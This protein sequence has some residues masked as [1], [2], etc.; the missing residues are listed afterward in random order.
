[1]KGDFLFLGF[2][3]PD[4][5]MERVFKVDKSPAVQ[6]HK[7][8]WN[9][10]K[11]LESCNDFSYTYISTRPVSEYCQYPKQI[12]F[13]NRWKTQVLN[14]KIEILEIPF[15]NRSVF[16]IITR[17]FSG[18][19]YS[20]KEYNKKANKKGVIVYSVHVPFMLIGYVISKIY[21]IDFIAI[22]TDPPSV[23]LTGEKLL[24]SKLRSLELFISKKLMI[25]ATKVIAVTKELAKDF[26]PESP[27]LV[28]EGI[29]DQNYTN[30][31]IYLKEKNTKDIIKVVYTGSLSKRY[32]ISNIVEAFELLRDENV[33]LEIYGWGDYEEEL[34]LICIKNNNIR[35]KGFVSNNDVINI[36]RSADFL[37]NA[38]SAEDEYVRYSFPSKTLEYML[39]GTPL[40]T[41]ILPSMPDEYKDY[42]LVI[43]DNNPKTICD[44][45]LKLAKLEIEERNNIGLKAIDFAKSK[46]YYNLSKRITKFISK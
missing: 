6:T 11:S 9:L 45:L 44:K 29:I 34:K 25:K 32:G 1:M 13:K 33:V 18:M 28:V 12:I 38:R 2:L 7:F 4:E 19:Y 43:E 42:V 15:I 39:S 20:F 24:K 10:V 46:S 31:E 26:A 41:T 37:I 27:Y 30:K 17:F 5:E 36:Q 16:K 3:I 23:N 14:K 22:W 8:N 21:K 35:Y 40:I